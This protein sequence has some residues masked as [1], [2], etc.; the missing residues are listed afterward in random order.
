M[1]KKCD[2]NRLGI[3]EIPK[4]TGFKN[5]GHVSLNYPA[6]VPYACMLGGVFGAE[7]FV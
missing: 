1:L 6:I 7:T 4:P 3:G 2:L 5:H